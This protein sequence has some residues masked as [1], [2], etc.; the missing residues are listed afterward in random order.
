[1]HYSIRTRSMWGGEYVGRVEPLSAQRAGPQKAPLST[2]SANLRRDI[3]APQNEK[4]G[5]SCI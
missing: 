1:M 4:L 3:T 2:D 5:P